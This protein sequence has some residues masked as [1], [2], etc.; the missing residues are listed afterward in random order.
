MG[1][2]HP[3]EKSTLARTRGWYFA[4]GKVVLIED[5]TTI[6]LSWH[7]IEARVRNY[8]CD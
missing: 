2:V 4:I 7:R 3:V 5:R 6:L 1:S 8:Q